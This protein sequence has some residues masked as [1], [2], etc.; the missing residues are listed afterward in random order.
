MDAITIYTDNY[1]QLYSMWIKTLP[2]GFNPISFKLETNKTEFGFRTESWYDA[3]EFQ[4][5]SVLN[6]L[7]N[8]NHNEI[9]LVSDS[10]IF[11]IK[12]DHTLINLVTNHFNQNPDL[13]IWISREN[14]SNHV[15]TGFYFLK[16]NQKTKNFISNGLKVCK[17]LNL[18]DQ[19]YFNNEL[20]RYLKWNFIPNEYAIWAT[21]IYDKNN[22][23]FHHATCA[24]NVEQKLNQQ[25]TILSLLK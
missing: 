13:D 10:D 25:K 3:I 14:T 24:Y 20:N 5:I 4:L 15:N 6:V 7:N 17:Q 18:A 2:Q 16:N 8:K 19:A 21:E 11:F 22:A 9:I 12:K 23:I 1:V